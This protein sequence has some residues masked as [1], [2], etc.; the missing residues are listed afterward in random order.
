[1]E[2]HFYVLLWSILYQ[3]TPVSPVSLSQFSWECACICECVCV[4]ERS[5]VLHEREK[6]QRSVASSVWNTCTEEGEDIDVLGGCCAK[7]P[8]LAF[9]CLAAPFTISLCW[10]KPRHLISPISCCV[11]FL[12]NCS[13]NAVSGVFTLLKRSAPPNHLSAIG[14]S[15]S[16]F[17][18]T[19]PSFLFLSPIG[20]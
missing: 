12:G 7:G 11:S 14:S 15:S 16:T 5:E 10:Q 6:V 18:F 8:W 20:R 17:S 19:P 2:R 9:S 3:L 1:M 13:S 4:C